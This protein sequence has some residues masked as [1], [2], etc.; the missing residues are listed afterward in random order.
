M[1][2]VVLS[3]ALLLLEL[4]LVIFLQRPSEPFSDLEPFLM[5]KTG[6]YSHTK[7]WTTAS[8]MLFRPSDGAN[9][10]SDNDGLNVKSW[11]SFMKNSTGTTSEWMVS[12]MIV[13]SKVH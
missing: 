3:V 4:N 11:T 8:S 10:R 1:P 7:I 6:R 13:W 2:K 12:M 9:L 5:T